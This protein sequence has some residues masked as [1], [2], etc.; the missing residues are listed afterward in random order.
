MVEG[1]PVPAAIPWHR[2][3]G[4]ILFLL[5]FVGLIRLP[6]ELLH[7]S[8]HVSP[9]YFRVFALDVLVG[10]LS[11]IAG[12]RILKEKP[13]A[14]RLVVS[15][16]GLSLP[17]TVYW[18]VQLGSWVL[19]TTWDSRILYVSPR[20]FFYVLSLAAWPYALRLLLKNTAELRRVL[21]A[22]LGAFL[23]IAAGYLLQF[24]LT[25]R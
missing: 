14:E 5:G 18:L 25:N 20:L 17:L 16:A 13:G 10:G 11:L 24:H 4:W 6:A 21:F 3:V 12:R 1:A 15:I 8:G 23:L 2:R 22:Y 7:L 9:A 19:R